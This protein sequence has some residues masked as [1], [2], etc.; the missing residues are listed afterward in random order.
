MVGNWVRPVAGSWAMVSVLFCFVLFLI[1]VF[2]LVW[3]LRWVVCPS[4][5]SPALSSL[6]LLALSSLSHTLSLC[7]P[8]SPSLLLYLS[9]L[10]GL[11]IFVIVFSH[12]KQTL[13]QLKT[14]RKKKEK[15]LKNNTK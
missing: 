4:Q 14:K 11:S 5:S 15:N 13:S 3:F 12:G 2:F 9:R 8:C 10:R 7:P 6:S 1:F